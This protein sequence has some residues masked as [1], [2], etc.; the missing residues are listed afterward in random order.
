MDA[1]PASQAAPGKC[2]LLGFVLNQFKIQNGPLWARQ[3]SELG[4]EHCGLEGF[5]GA[6]VAEDV[7]C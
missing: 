6:L 4:I 2:L 1:C 7:R 3:R 5:L